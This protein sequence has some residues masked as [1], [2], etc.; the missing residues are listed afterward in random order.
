M[1]LPLTQLL[2]AVVYDIIVSYW[3][4]FKGADFENRLKSLNG[5]FIKKNTGILRVMTNE[6]SI[7][8]MW[9]GWQ[10]IAPDNFDSVSDN[11]LALASF[12]H[13]TFA[14]MCRQVLATWNYEHLRY[15]PNIY[16]LLS[17]Q[18]HVS[19][20]SKKII[21]NKETGHY[22]MF[23][24]IAHATLITCKFLLESFQDAQDTKIKIEEW[25]DLLYPQNH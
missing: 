13:V 22:H 9:S 7:Q 10:H 11:K 8:A 19:S 2:R 20:F 17:Q 24:A 3:L 16:T 6:A 4:L 5:D 12:T 21:Y 23:D 15:L 1:A 25:L 18:A 14:E